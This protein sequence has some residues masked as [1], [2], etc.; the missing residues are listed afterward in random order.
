MVTQKETP[1]F[2]ITFDKVMIG[3]TADEKELGLAVQ[4]S[5]GNILVDILKSASN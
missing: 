3:H 5:V 1:T 4:N 2:N